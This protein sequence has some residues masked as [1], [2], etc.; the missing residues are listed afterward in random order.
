MAK[1]V[2]LCDECHGKGYV[3]GHTR[4]EPCEWCHGTG[5]KPKSSF[6]TACVIYIALVGAMLAACLA[7]AFYR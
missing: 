1:E 7:I 3:M 5:F 2:E 4:F 6:V